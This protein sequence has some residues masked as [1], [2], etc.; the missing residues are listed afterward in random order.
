MSSDKEVLNALE[1]E[2]HTI[3]GYEVS[4][5]LP[6][7][8]TALCVSACDFCALQVGVR[9]DRRDPLQ[10]NSADPP[11]TQEF[12]VDLADSTPS[13]SSHVTANDALSQ[14]DAQTTPPANLSL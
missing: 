3:E 9:R 8:I 7:F 13:T 14:P 10:L 5:Q 1:H 6:V 2:R 11:S 4:N 12:A